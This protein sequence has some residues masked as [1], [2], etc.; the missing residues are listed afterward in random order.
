MCIWKNHSRTLRWKTCTGH[1]PSMTWAPLPSPRRFE[2]TEEV[3]VGVS[4][5]VQLCSPVLR[6]SGVFLF[7]ET[8]KPRTLLYTDSLVCGWNKTWPRMA[9][10]FH[11]RCAAGQSTQNS[12]K[13][14]GEKWERVRFQEL[15][16]A[17]IIF[18]RLKWL[19]KPSRWR[20]R[21][22]DIRNLSLGYTQQS[23]KIP[24]IFGQTHCLGG[25][26]FWLTLRNCWSNTNLWIQNSD[27][28]SWK[29]S[30]FSKTATFSYK[31][32]TI[33]L[34]FAKSYYGV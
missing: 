17:A 28:S 16:W 32:P 3:A 21:P 5:A 12:L 31:H 30:S 6:G 20:A 1:Q 34:F 14:K 9:K 26:F 23:L 13:P 18:L 33:Q 10:A 22:P 4:A 24:W 2:E 8:L 15:A 11:P 7:S 27:L 19:R 25:T 29:L